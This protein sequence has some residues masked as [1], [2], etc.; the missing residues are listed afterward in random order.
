M[1]KDKGDTP[2]ACA[3]SGKELQG[4]EPWARGSQA[5]LEARDPRPPAEL[6]FRPGRPRARGGPAGARDSQSTDVC[7][8]RLL[9]VH[10]GGGVVCAGGRTQASGY[11]RA[12][13]PQV[14]GPHTPQD[15]GPGGGGGSAGLLG[16]SQTSPPPRPAAA[17][18]SPPP[19]PPAGI[20]HLRAPPVTGVGPEHNAPNGGLKSTP[21]GPRIGQEPL[22]AAAECPRVSLCPLCSLQTRSGI[23]EVGQ[24]SPPHGVGGAEKVRGRAD[25]QPGASGLRAGREVGPRHAEPLPPAKSPGHSRY[26][27][28]TGQGTLGPRDTDCGRHRYHSAPLL[29]SRSWGDREHRALLVCGTRG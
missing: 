11:G 13:G 29:S 17:S 9:H 26:S 18:G 8:I 7:L 10:L 28:N 4:Q 2:P 1:Q 21:Q 23:P 15:V 12:E 5:H 27:G 3:H 25:P 6:H 14:P 20:L 16:Q 22:G 19:A 24:L